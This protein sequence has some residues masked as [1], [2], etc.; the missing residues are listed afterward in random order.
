MSLSELIDQLNL[1]K[2]QMFN[3]QGTPCTYPNCMCKRNYL[4]KTLFYMDHSSSVDEIDSVMSGQSP[5]ICQCKVQ[6]DSL[7]AS[8]D[9]L[10][11]QINLKIN[12]VYQVDS[13]PFESS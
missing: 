2:Q 4:V 13:N 9:A 11:L 6:K 8:I 5:T 10:I 3:L 7:Q 12:E 1:A